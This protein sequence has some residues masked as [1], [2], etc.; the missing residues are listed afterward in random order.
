MTVRMDQT[1]PVI[2]VLSGGGVTVVVDVGN[3]L[4][5]V[6]YWG[7]ELAVDTA[8]EGFLGLLAHGQ[9]GADGLTGRRRI[10]AVLPEQSAGWMGTPG[11]E[12]HRNGRMF[13]TKFDRVRVALSGA[14]R[15][16]QALVTEAEDDAARLAARVTL[17]L[18]AS[19]VLRVRA[20]VTNTARDESYTVDSL[21][22]VLPV[23]AEAQEILHFAGRHLRER[24]PQRE[25]FHV[26]THLRE[27]RRGRTGSDATLLLAAGTAG[28]GF[29]QGQVWAVHTAWSGNHA[30][31]AELGLTGVRVL[32]GGEILL[33]GEVVLGAGESYSS[34][35]LYAV[36]GDGLDD[37][38]AKLHRHLRSRPRHPSTARPVV[39][40]TWEAV[41]F[42]HD[43]GSL[44]DLAKL[45]AEVGAERFVL[46]DGWFHGRRDDSAGLGDWRVDASVWPQGLG[47]L[48]EAVR[49]L[50][51]Q[52]GLWFEPEMVNSDSDLA[53]AHPEWILAPGDRLPLT[54]RNQHVLN[55]ALPEA[56]DYLLASMSA[57]ISD[58]EIDYIKWD[59][60]RDLVEAGDRMTGQPRVHQQTLA[61]YELM[62]ELHRRHPRLEI[63]SCSSGGGRV[64]LEVLERTDRVW[65]SDCID[66]LERQRIQRWTGLILPPELIGSHVGA[67]TAHTTRRTQSLAFR[68]A[69]ALFGHFGIEWD[70]RSVSA[71]A[72]NE[73]AAWVALYKEERALIH[74][75]TSVRCDYPDPAYWAH[76]MVSP[77]RRR[78]LFMFTSLDT[79][80]AAQPGWIRLPGLDPDV[81]Y[82]IDPV[83]L[84]EPALVRTRGGPP[85]WWT[86]PTTAS[87]GLLEAVGLQGPMLYPEQA[88]VFRLLAD[89][90]VE[91]KA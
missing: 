43:L 46:D 76:G 74:S 12:G 38:S 11:L 13:T 57:L 87:G 59:H 9:Q 30:T 66:A 15:D 62:D 56:F 37:V 50:G 48:V 91:K 79:S 41:Y 22:L 84:S 10:P 88:L 90:A 25:P 47:P 32:G 24:I 20:E 42:K 16:A 7:P 14:S 63:E 28:F 36:Y 23:P 81:S 21:R 8:D 44:V 31:F 71:D 82:R 60:N 55:L 29:H 53:R 19:G 61:V 67:P 5:S 65:A 2:R 33:P 40:N 68:A 49:G 58:Y 39:L 45:G 80:L 89:D 18:A 6:L 1:Q 85:T 3:G 52:F 77:D 26:G 27:G 73:L 78:A 69:T 75:G 4:P 64:D 70:L 83:R 72:L 35:W 54:G 51:M 34:P 17:E 86:D